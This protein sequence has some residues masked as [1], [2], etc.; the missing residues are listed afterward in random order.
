MSIENRRECRIG[1]V[2]WFAGV[3]WL[4]L[5]CIAHYIALGAARMGWL[6]LGWAALGWT[7]RA[8]RMAVQ[9]ARE[10]GAVD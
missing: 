5:S 8:A 3:F 4:G 6:S 7:T 1:S 2:P 10:G 9:C